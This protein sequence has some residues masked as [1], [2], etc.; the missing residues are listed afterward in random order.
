VPWYRKLG[1]DLL[2]AEATELLKSRQRPDNAAGGETPSP[3]S[4]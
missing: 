1:F 2:N 4:R 3:G